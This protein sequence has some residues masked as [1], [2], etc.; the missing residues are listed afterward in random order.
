[1][2]AAAATASVAVAF[3]TPCTFEERYVDDDVLIEDADSLSV[4]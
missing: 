3:R 1:M 2:R 4:L